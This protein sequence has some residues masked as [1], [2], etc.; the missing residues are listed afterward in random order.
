MK[1]KNIVLW[2]TISFLA[3]CAE[4]QGVGNV[5]MSELTGGNGN[6]GRMWITREECRNSTGKSIDEIA[7]QM[8]V[9]TSRLDTYLRESS[10]MLTYLIP[11][12]RTLH[13]SDN[14]VIGGLIHKTISYEQM[15]QNASLRYCIL[16]ISPKTKRVRS[17][18]VQ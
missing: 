11:I 3:A 1:M 7:K 14:T 10:E 12:D 17:F 6:S 8:G 15:S 16:D 9:E 18:S 2:C 13:K 4:L 5:F